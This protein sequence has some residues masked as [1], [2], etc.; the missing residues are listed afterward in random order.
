VVGHA[1]NR[2]LLGSKI[3]GEEPDAE[4]ALHAVLRVLLRTSNINECI[5]ADYVFKC[6]CEVTSRSELSACYRVHLIIQ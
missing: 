1:K 3:V 6:F 5:A 4:P 2:D